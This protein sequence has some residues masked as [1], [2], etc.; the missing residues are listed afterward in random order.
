MLKSS[1]IIIKMGNYMDFDKLHAKRKNFLETNK[2][3]DHITLIGKNNIL[4]SAPHGVSQVRL[5]KYKVAEIGSI[6]TALYLQNK[7]NSFLIAKTKNNNNDANF[8]E[9]SSYKDEIKKLLKK[10][11]I[12]YFIDFHGLSE[13]RDCDINLGTHLG[14]NIQN[15]IALFDLLQKELESHFSVIIDQPYMA[16]SRTLSG[17]LKHEF[18]DLWTIQIE[19]NCGITNKR[20]NFKRFKILLEILEKWLNDI[21][22]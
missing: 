9:E 3:K 22:K 16:E 7:T 14:N 6:T 5:G 12:K 13:K 2:L 10:Y 1:K 19:I 15:N 21:P 20:K 11:N 8:D 17:S 4:I 18:E